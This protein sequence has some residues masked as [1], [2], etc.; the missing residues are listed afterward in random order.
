VVD[1][2]LLDTDILSYFFRNEPNVVANVDKYLLHQRRLSISVITYYEVLRGLRFVKATR[3][4][5]D[6]QQFVQDCEILPLSLTAIDYAADIYVALRQEGQLINEADI[7]IAGIAL[8]YDVVLVT[9]NA[10]HF[11]RIPQ[12]KIVNWLGL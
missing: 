5:Y 12:L 2:H 11:G 1:K 3:Q 6:L 7:L 10:S 4:L 8:A 9:N